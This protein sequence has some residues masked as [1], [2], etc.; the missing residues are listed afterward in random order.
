MEIFARI[1]SDI[2]QAYAAYYNQ[3]ADTF[4]KHIVARRFRLILEAGCGR[5][6]LTIPLLR[7]LPNRVRMIAVDSS[8]GPY[9]GWL[10]ELTQLLAR[11]KLENRVDVIEADATRIADVKPG[12]VDAVVSNELLC[13]L[14]PNSRLIRA[15][16]EFRRI[17]RDNGM[18]V[19][20]EWSS[21]SENDP[22][23]IMIKHFPSWTPDQ[24]HSATLASGFRNF[25]VSY[26]ETTIRFQ[27]AAALEELHNWGASSRLLR[28]RGNLVKGEG[29]RLPFEHI[30]RCEKGPARSRFQPNK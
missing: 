4:A 13:D 28:K 22:R 26:F 24:L 18:M 21:H 27:Y 19:H 2:P 9:R 8:R 15:L 17:L 23:S 20:G 3:M 16:R 30:I 14:V 25:S 6:Q 7:K 29:F 12:S 11:A 5:G 10:D 1:P